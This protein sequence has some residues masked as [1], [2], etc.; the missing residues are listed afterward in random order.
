MNHG[1]YG[2]EQVY[3]VL[4]EDSMS[5]GGHTVC[6]DGQTDPA[7]AAA[8]R[9]VYTSTSNVVQVRLVTLQSAQFLIKVE[10]NT[11]SSIYSSASYKMWRSA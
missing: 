5:G 9:V 6:A 2:G 11:S 8:A 3:A 10:R 1:N 4:R 7:T